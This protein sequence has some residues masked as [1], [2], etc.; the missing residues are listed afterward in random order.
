[1]YG[2]VLRLV[3]FKTLSTKEL[4]E[5]LGQK[6]KSGQLKKVLAKLLKDD[7]VEWTEPEKT[8]SKQQYRISQKGKIFL[9]LLNQLIE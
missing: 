2:K 4:S 5:S 1:M 7:L 9:N 8:S 6:S 3:Q